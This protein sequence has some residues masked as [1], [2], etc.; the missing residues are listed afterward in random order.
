M[1]NEKSHF[2]QSV[3]KWLFYCYCAFRMASATLN[4]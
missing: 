4:P 1:C 3:S 2:E